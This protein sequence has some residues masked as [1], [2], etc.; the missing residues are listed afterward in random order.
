MDENIGQALVEEIFA[1]RKPIHESLAKLPQSRRHSNGRRIKLGT[2]PTQLQQDITGIVCISSIE[3]P[4][5]RGQ[6][7]PPPL[8]ETNL[9]LRG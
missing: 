5:S 4:E 1:E 3:K 9:A 6:A 8:P 2:T 7:T